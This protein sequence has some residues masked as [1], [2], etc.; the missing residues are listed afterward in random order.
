MYAYSNLG[1]VALEAGDPAAA[2]Q[3]F[4][5]SNDIARQIAG[6]NPGEAF[7]WIELREGLSWSGST[8]AALGD[9]AGARSRYVD[10]VEAAERARAIADTPVQVFEWAQEMMQLAGANRK[11]GRRDAAEA[12]Y[13]EALQ[14]LEQSVAH[15]PENARWRREEARTHYRLAEL[16]LLAARPERADIHLAGALEGFHQLVSQD[17]TNL[18]FRQDRIDA[19]RLDA[20]RWLAAGKT[21]LAEERLNGIRSEFES[22]LDES[23][24]ASVRFGRARADELLGRLH[25][26][27]GEPAAAATAWQRA[28]D[29]LPAAE[30]SELEEVALRARLLHHLGRD[31][32]AE[33][34]RIRLVESAFRD[35]LFPLPE[36]S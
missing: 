29:T 36:N 26:A 6:D 15:D 21:G 1:S 11:L 17:P 3:H 9:L 5:A 24:L 8:L 34:L 32:E 20:E 4:E 28:L 23:G 27:R 14:A 18:K 12:L 10:A 25:A 19:W 2:L 30:Q 22:G 13:G 7:G 35:P 16:A 33:S 31:A